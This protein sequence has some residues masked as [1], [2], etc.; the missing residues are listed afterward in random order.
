MLSEY[1]KTVIHLKF[2]VESY[3]GLFVTKTT[4]TPSRFS[5]ICIQTKPNQ[6]YTTKMKYKNTFIILIF[7]L[8]L[9]ICSMHPLELEGSVEPYSVSSW[10]QVGRDEIC[11]NTKDGNLTNPELMY[12][13]H[14]TLSNQ[15]P[16]L[17]FLVHVADNSSSLSSRWNQRTDTNQEIIS[18]GTCFQ[19]TSKSVFIYSAPKPGCAQQLEDRAAW[20][21]TEAAVAYGQKAAV[22]SSSTV[23]EHTAAYTMESGKDVGVFSDMVLVTEGYFIVHNFDT[24]CLY[25][26]S[27]PVHSRGW[28][29][30]TIG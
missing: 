29:M 9:R 25:Q 7:S 11:K 17:V 5:Y 10:E 24:R 22:S 12:L 14:S 30:V 23:L 3:P 21:L 28:V 20:V 15:F 6:T 18:T 4:Q 2:T 13:I 16:N 8:T 27:L 26:R 1:I 19:D